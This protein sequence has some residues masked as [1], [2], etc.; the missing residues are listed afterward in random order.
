M[1][2]EMSKS[3][4]VLGAGGFIGGAL[5]RY[6]SAQGWRV[7]AASRQPVTFDDPRIVNVVA[8][9][10]ERAHF[11][12]WMDKCDTVVHAASLTTPSSSAAHPQ[13]DGNLRSTL[14]LIEALQE[15]PGKR[16]LYLSSGGALYEEREGLVGEATPLRPRSYHGAGKAAAEHFIQAWAAQY[17]GVATIVRPSNVYGPGQYPRPGFG[18]IPATFECLRHGKALQVWGD[19]TNV[20]DYLYIDDLVSLCGSVMR[21]SPP[22]SE[23]DVVNASSGFGINLIEL[24]ARIERV[25]GEVVAKQFLPSRVI[26]MRRIVPDSGRAFRRFDWRAQV[27]LDEGLT[28]AW[29]WYRNMYG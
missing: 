10:S 8:P 23:V 19:G 4:F 24:L 2:R 17:G 25:T 28:A 22:G 18:I 21:T 29:H 15:L 6:F 11:L 3:V 20:R 27:E 1:L 13:L 7:L 16:L 26:D 9:F 12:P 14:A 5:S